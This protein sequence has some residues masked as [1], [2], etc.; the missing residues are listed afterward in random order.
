MQLGALEGRQ[1]CVQWLL[2]APATA[3]VVEHVCCYVFGAALLLRMLLLLRFAGLRGGAAAG[4]VLVPELRA[5]VVC[6]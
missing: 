6:E 4:V 1:M 2:T 5:A 3:D